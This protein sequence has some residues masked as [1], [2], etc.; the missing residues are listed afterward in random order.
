MTA[1]PLS[2][3]MF[4]ASL[5][6]EGRRCLVVG[7]GRVAAR[8]AAK[9]VEAGALLTVVAPAIREQIKALPNI[10]LCERAFEESDLTETYLVFAVTDNAALNRRIVD[11]CREKG[12]NH[13]VYTG[14]ALNWCLLLSPGGMAEMHKY[15]FMCSALRQ[16][17]TAVENKETAQ[18]QLCMEIALWRVALAYGF[19]FDVDDFVK[20]IKK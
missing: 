15:G 11:L 18:R 6:L 19:V 2:K 8:K 9:L 3:K 5:L 4:P 17:T 13:L 14:F 1:A 20:A 16:A 10:E 7:G 12:I